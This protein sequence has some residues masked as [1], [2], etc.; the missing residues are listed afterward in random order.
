M[1]LM[2]QTFRSGRKSGRLRLMNVNERTGSFEG[3]ELK[4]W[5][6]N[7]SFALNIWELARKQIAAGIQEDLISS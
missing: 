4:G 2:A 1:Y 3:V 5:K 6:Q 7:G